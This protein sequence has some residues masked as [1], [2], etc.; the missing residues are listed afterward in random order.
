MTTWL[1]SGY[2]AETSLVVRRSRFVTTLARVDDE[3]AARALIAAVRRASPDA[4]HHCTAFVV[5]VPGARPVER[6]S[7]DGE[8]S[9]TA[10]AP[11]LDVLRGAGV[12]Q[13]VAVVSRW[14]GGV[15]LGTGG[16]VRAYS[17]A[18]AA[19]LAAAPRVRP[20]VWRLVKLTVGPGDAG[21]VQGALLQRGID[22]MEAVW[23]RAV[24]LTLAVA[25]VAVA[26]AVAREVLAGEVRLV[27]VGEVVREVPVGSPRH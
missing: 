19:G 5:E 23:E 14:F 17:D 25:D 12:T 21:R 11:M 10:G 16:L 9:G 13:V 3:D 15:L 2:R 8:P 7:D 22:V 6:S 4:G 24:T 27:E 18:V 1:P 26:E 20:E